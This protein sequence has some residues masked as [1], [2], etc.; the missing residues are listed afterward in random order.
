MITQEILTNDGIKYLYTKSDTY[1]I[2]QVETN[3]VYEDALDLIP[4]PYTYEETDIP[5][6]EPDEQPTE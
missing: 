4:C 1:K 5:L 6:P 2:R 3:E